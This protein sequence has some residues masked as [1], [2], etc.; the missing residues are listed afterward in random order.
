MRTTTPTIALAAVLLI[1][2]CRPDDLQDTPLLSTDC[3]MEGSRIE[4]TVDGDDWCA[5]ASVLAIGSGH[6]VVLITGVTLSG[7]V[8]TLQIDS[9]AEGGFAIDEMNNAV[10]FMEGGSSFTSTDASPGT[11]TVLWSDTVAYRVSGTI[12][13][14]LYDAEDPATRSVEGSFDV[15]YTIE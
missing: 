13:V 10:L 2:S 7:S 14:T 4:M 5:N 9:I 1:T 15:T 12:E 6:G 8:I 3:G 11:L